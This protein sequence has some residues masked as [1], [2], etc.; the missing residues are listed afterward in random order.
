M[1]DEQLAARYQEGASV[2]QL[3]GESGFGRRR[4]M[5]ALERTGTKLRDNPSAR[6]P[7]PL[8]PAEVP[9][10]HRDSFN[11]R[12]Q[13][14]D[15]IGDQR[16]GL[17]IERTCSEC[18]SV[19]TVVVSNLRGDLRR[20]RKMRPGKCGDCKGRI[21]SGEGY[22]WILKPDHPRAY[23]GKYVPEHVLVMEEALGRYLDTDNESVHHIDGD[24][25][26]NDLSNLQLRT[27]FHGKGQVRRC[28]NCGSND[29]ETLGL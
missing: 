29:I 22:V 7:A 26:N 4:I 18:Q 11:F 10:E 8:L 9:D 1:N 19:Y 24:R 5:S 14:T 6:I 21:I 20:G 17:V 13:Y 2:T 25:Q 3:M 27:R 15:G 16:R 23:S 12:R 28:R